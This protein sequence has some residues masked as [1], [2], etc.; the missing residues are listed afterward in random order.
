MQAI[1]DDAAVTQARQDLTAAQET[2]TEEAKL[3]F[4]LPAAQQQELQHIVSTVF[5]TACQ[6]LERDHEG[7][8]DSDK[9]N[10]RVLNNRQVLVHLLGSASCATMETRLH[11]ATLQLS[12]LTHLICIDVS[13][14]ILAT[15]SSTPRQVCLLQ[16]ACAEES[17]QKI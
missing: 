6:Q 12:F 7:L 14:A 3:R 9:E 4:E 2:H 1:N 13:L 16:H 15:T 17:Y 10:S 5:Q 8:I 11:C